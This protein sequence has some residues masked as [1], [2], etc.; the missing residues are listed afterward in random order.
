MNE[1]D[2][3]DIVRDLLPGYV[4]GILSEAGMK[5]V[6]SHLEICEEC[7]KIYEEMKNGMD[8]EEN[9]NEVLVLDGLK[10][11]RKRTGRLKLICGVISGLFAVLLGGVCLVLF[12]IGRPVSTSQLGITDVVYHEDSDS[13]VIDG[14]IDNSYASV[15]KVILEQSGENTNALNV[16]VYGV[17]PFPGS[18]KEN[19][20][21]TVPGAKGKKIYL[22]CPDYDRV[23]L[24]NWKNDHYELM[25]A[26]EEEIY[27]RVPQLDRKKDILNYGGGIQVLDG[28]E[29]VSY[30]VEHLL[31]EDVTLWRFND[32]LITD[33]E[34]EPAGFDVWISLEE[35]HQILFY[36]YET[37]KWSEKLPV[38]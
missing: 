27:R 38:R 32:Q 29:G 20:T 26:L 17:E 4:D 9:G 3:C 30:G 23:E 1:N 13:L 28:V 36:D 7:Q 15:G 25:D 11:I 5:A 35:P 19:F 10:R 31:G 6:G 22:A 24:Y 2:F 34:L 16:I 21:V 33:G 18:R 14:Y 37:G 12:V 8:E